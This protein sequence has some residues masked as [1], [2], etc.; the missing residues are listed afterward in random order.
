MGTKALAEPVV[1]R[2]PQHAQAPAPT[3][4]D[5]HPPSPAQVDRLAF[6]ASIAGGGAE[7]L[8]SGA[9]PTVIDN[10]K[11]V[12][13]NGFLWLNE[14]AQQEIGRLEHDLR[15]N[16]DPPFAERLIRSALKVALGAG[17]AAAGELIKGKLLGVA[18]EFGEHME[19]LVKGLFEEGINAGVAAG[20]E[21]VG[22]GGSNTIT[23]F[24]ESQK[25]AVR[26]AHATNQ[27]HWIDVGRHKLATARDAESLRVACNTPNMKLAGQ[28][29]Y[30]AT[31]DAWVGYLAQSRFGAVVRGDGADRTT[32]TDMASKARTDAALPAYGLAPGVL[33]VVAEL[34]NIRIP[35]RAIDGKPSVRIAFLNGVNSVIRDQYAGK[36]LSAIKIPRQIVAA[37][38]ENFEGFTLN[39]DE[40]GNLSRMPKA[41]TWLKANAVLRSPSSHKEDEDARVDI[42]VKLLLDDLVPEQIKEKL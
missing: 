34:P 15:Q 14:A 39:L 16:D 18:T 6:A 11:K 3:T 22:G 17:S 23:A 12:I 42:G 20:E 41:T 5:H 26:A 29:Q 32:V 36:P 35:E 38:T 28:R 13:E 9:A 37:G 19:E 8:S 1:R 30:A 33:G 4:A 40:A 21:K 2:A 25:E 24:I 10:A 27:T 7:G 31:R